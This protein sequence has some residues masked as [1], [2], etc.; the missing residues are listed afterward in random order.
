M[1]NSWQIEPPFRFGFGQLKVSRSGNVGPLRLTSIDNLTCQ[2]SVQDKEPTCIA[3]GN[4][5][6]SRV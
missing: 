6:V 5:E 2:N 1:A 3:S 4:T